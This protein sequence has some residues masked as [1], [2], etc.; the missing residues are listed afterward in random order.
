[1]IP[2][3][4]AV[5]ELVVIRQNVPGPGRAAAAHDRTHTLPLRRTLVRFASAGGP[6]P[7]GG[8]GIRIRSS[9]GRGAPALLPLVSDRGPDGEV[10][11]VLAVPRVS[12]LAAAPVRVR[13]KDLPDLIRGEIQLQQRVRDHA[14]A[15]VAVVATASILARLDC[16]LPGDDDLD[17]PPVHPPLFQRLPSPDVLQL[18]SG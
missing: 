14:I 7:G 17:H 13:L 1:V 2:D 10:K 18:R 9:A 11:V 15:R 12:Y 16:P 6:A 8:A 3:R 4:A 5:V